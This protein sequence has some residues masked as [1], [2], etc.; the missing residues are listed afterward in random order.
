MDWMMIRFYTW[1]GIC[2]SMPHLS[3]ATEIEANASNEQ[4]AI[5]KALRIQD[6]VHLG[7]MNAKGF[8]PN[9]SSLLILD[10][11]NKP[12]DELKASLS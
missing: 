7:A 12:S 11:D 1:R 4:M 2:F 8:V 5:L 3:N 10:D 6:D 9:A